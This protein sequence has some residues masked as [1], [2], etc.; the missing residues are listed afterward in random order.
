MERERR[1]L[2]KYNRE[3]A[4]QFGIDPG[5]PDA[6]RQTIRVDSIPTPTEVQA[7]RSARPA[8]A[9]VNLEEAVLNILK[10]EMDELSIRLERFGVS[11]NSSMQQE[12]VDFAMAVLSGMAGGG[13]LG[14]R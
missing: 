14:R 12:M 8:Q 11:F 13:T 1:P 9:H 6:P 4:E 3:L 7:P 2:P 10:E 5:V